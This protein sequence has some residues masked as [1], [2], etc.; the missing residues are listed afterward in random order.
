[1]AIFFSITGTGGK[2]FNIG[3]VSY[4]S[5]YVQSKNSSWTYIFFSFDAFHF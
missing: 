1:M 5:A 3:S 2:A 4:V